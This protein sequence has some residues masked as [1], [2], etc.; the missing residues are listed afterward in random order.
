MKCI[1]VPSSWLRITGAWGAE[2]NLNLLEEI[3]RRGIALTDLHQVSQVWEELKAQAEKSV[4][5]AKAESARRRELATVA[6]EALNDLAV[7]F[8]SLRSKIKGGK[9][10]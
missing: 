2:V 6:R 5:E 1:P 4:A 9:P 8:P 7:K 10:L 3:N